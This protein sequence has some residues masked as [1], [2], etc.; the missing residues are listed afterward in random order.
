MDG[1]RVREREEC[2]DRVAEIGE[3]E[4]RREREGCRCL[5]RQLVEVI[6]GKGRQV[7]R[8]GRVEDERRWR[9]RCD[10]SAP[11]HRRWHKRGTLF[12]FVCPL[13]VEFEVEVD[14]C[15]AR[16]VVVGPH[17][18]V[19]VLVVVGVLSRVIPS[20]VERLEDSAVVL[21][22]CVA[23]WPPSKAP[24]PLL[25]ERHLVNRATK[26]GRDRTAGPSLCPCLCLKM[27]RMW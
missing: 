8:E 14:E 1:V 7:E 24:S 4:E 9:C 15:G 20:R 26:F 23:E 13:E 11:N 25:R 5:V 2:C 27:G 6:A 3:G 22:S 16:A 10:W 19:V 17:S 12:A 21:A 18:R